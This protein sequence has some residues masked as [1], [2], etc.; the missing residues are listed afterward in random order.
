M[1]KA[2]D[3]H[4]IESQLRRI[5]RQNHVI[6]VFALVLLLALGATLVMLQ[7]AGGTWDNPLSVEN[8]Y[9]LVVALGGL[10]VL[11]SL[12]MLYKQHQLH[13]LRTSLFK[14][15]LREESLRSRLSS[16]SSFFERVSQVGSQLEIGPILQALTEHLRTSL[17]ADHAS[18]ML[19]EP[20]AH[21][22]RGQAVAGAD[23]ENVRQA[24]IPLG[25]GV[26]GAVAV[27]R[28]ALVLD[29]A[30][31][32]KRFPSPREP[33][34]SAQGALCVPLPVGD[35]AIGVVNVVRL[36]SK[37][38]FTP[39]DARLVSVF[40]AH[41]AIALKRITERLEAEEKLRLREDQLRQAQKMEA[42]GRLAGGVAHD[43]NNLLTVILSYSRRL[44]QGTPVDG[45]QCGE[46]ARK[47]Q[48]AGERCGALTRQLLAF[49][50]K[51]VLENTVLD[52]NQSVHD[53]AE[54]LARM[55]GE[56]VEIEVALDPVLGAIRADHSQV[57]QV[58]LNLAL[59]AR[60]AM[61][62][63]G[64]LSIETANARLDDTAAA[65]HGVAAGRY[66]L[67]RVSDTGVG[68]DDSARQH[69][70]EPFFTTKRNGTGL[71]LATVYG[72]VSQSGGFVQVESRAGAGTTF[73]IYLPATDAEAPAAEGEKPPA[74]VAGT[75]GTVLLVEDEKELRAIVRTMLEGDGFTV[76]DA[77]WAGE[78][79][80]LA[81]ERA[82]RV[83]LLVTDVVMPGE[84]GGDL[85]RWMSERW[86]AIPVL[87][88]SGYPDDEIVRNGAHH[89]GVAFLQKPFDE[90]TLLAKVHE[91]ILNSSAA[92]GNGGGQPAVPE[93]GRA[94]RPL[95]ESGPARR[96]TAER[97]EGPR[98]AA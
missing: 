86:S 70:F 84:S 2:K 33:F 5:E 87:Y 59:N 81:E 71:G 40:A 90:T 98:A 47:I 49:S 57:E 31:I 79:V 43:F 48:D 41:V 18:L 30:E 14:A 52:L 42:L 89:E 55:L 11:F 36:E 93:S 46:S 75:R 19:Y 6:W 8:R 45:C 73:E 37:T 85:A 23:L 50:R 77:A 29:A 67:L 88:M 60:D 20:A 64:R 58:L 63:G 83:D 15:I 91:L 22:L 24:I 39:E 4:P 61:P 69:A 97:G 82:G 95:V 44:A 27:T 25:E 7:L 26:A 21:G 9:P 17:E 68:M 96:A 10:V 65:L 92:D 78:A 28:E 62:A 12:Y 1:S 3:H 56:R 66:V 72:I 38:P 74:H 32:A 34:R 35:Q 51:Q 16:L 13:D 76:V 80:M 94:R 53:A 54:L